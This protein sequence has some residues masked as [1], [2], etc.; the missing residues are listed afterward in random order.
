MELFVQELLPEIYEDFINGTLNLKKST[1]LSD[2]CNTNGW[3]SVKHLG[4]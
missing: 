4:Q 3:I 2:R 1:S